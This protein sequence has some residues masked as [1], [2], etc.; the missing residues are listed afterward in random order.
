M[1]SRK[2]YAD[3]MSASVIGETIRFVQDDPDTKVVTV[4]TGELISITTVAKAVHVSLGNRYGRN[5]AEYMLELNQV[6][7]LDPSIVQVVDIP[8][9]RRR[10]QRIGR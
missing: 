8:E 1:S 5:R 10:R 4:V 7:E 2:L 3:E 9:L 6:V